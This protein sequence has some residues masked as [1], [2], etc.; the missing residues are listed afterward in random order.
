MY[1]ILCIFLFWPP[2]DILSSRAGE[3]I[4]DAVV[5]Y[6]AAV[7]TLNPLT[8]WAGWGSNLHPGTVDTPLVSFATVGTRVL[9]FI[10]DGGEEY[11]P[12]PHRV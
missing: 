10:M 6:A 7:A 9:Y 11:L 2:H 3:Q 5:T 4:Q 12:F 8:H 1:F